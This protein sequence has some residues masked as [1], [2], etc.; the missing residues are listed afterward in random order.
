MSY[1]E[2]LDA[3]I[4][5][6]SQS[7]FEVSHSE[8]HP[9]LKSHQKDVVV[10]NLA[11][12][13]RANFLSFGLG[14]TLIQLETLRQIILHKGGR[15]LI[16]CPLG[17]KHEFVRDALKIGI[18][19]IKYIVN[20][21]QIEE[22]VD[23][24]I[25]NYER[26]RKGD[27]DPFEFIGVSFDE[28][29]ILRGL[30][31]QTTDMIMSMFKDI[32]F[33]FVCTATPSP[34]RYLELT[35]YAEYLGIMDRG[36]ILTRFFERNSTTAG[37]LKLYKRRQ[38]EFWYWMASWACFIT[39]PSDLGYDDTGY[40]LPPIN[41]H[42]HLVTF[43]RDLNVDTRSNQVSFLADSSKSLSEASKEKRESL[44]YRIDK[45]IEIVNQSPDDHFL[46]WHHLEAERIAIEK[47]VPDCKTVFGAQKTDL[48]ESILMDFSEGKIKY[49]GT[50]PEIAG[51]GCNFQ[52]HCH[53]AI[54]IGINYK[55]NDF[56]QAIHRIYR[57]MQSYP[58]DVHIILTDAEQEIFKELMRK[59]H[60]HI[61]IQT[62]M[63][64]IIKEFGLNSELYKEDLKREFFDPQK[65]QVFEGENF[66]A[67]NNDSVAECENFKDNSI[68]MIL[69]SIPF[70][71]H[72]EYSENINCFGHNETNE[73]F[74]EQMDHLT[75]NLF[76][77][78]QPGRIAFVH[79]K[80]RIRYSYMNGTGFTTIE[81]F[82]DH[83]NSHFLRHGFHLLAR[84]T[85]TTDVVAENAQTYRLGYTE[86]CKD[87][88][89]MGAGMPEY[90]LIFRKPPS[91]N[92]NAY[93]DVPVVHQKTEYERARW[94]LDAHDYWKS[95]GERLLDSNFLKQMDLSEVLKIWT[96]MEHHQ[97]YDYE[98]HVQLC[99]MLD[100]LG[101]LPT[102]Y[103]STPP[104]SN[105]PFVWSDIL[106]MNT[107]N[108]DQV[109]RNL[110]K[111]IC[112]LQLDIIKR[113]IELFSNKGDIIFDPFAGIFST[114][115]QAIKMERVG[116]GCELNS[117]YWKD[118]VKH[119]RTAELK[120]KSKTMTLF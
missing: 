88:T 62:E 106:R 29:S 65:R 70:G 51:S 96:E 103:M 13:R 84:I 100:D 24:Y 94:Q 48:K 95:N 64:N 87:G 57:F 36:Q 54:F 76:R 26:I 3:K 60:D 74:F 34:N 102:S 42:R 2:C 97:G 115:Y 85:V 53:K 14:K 46:L 56:I 75:P 4:K 111:H 104:I 30:D 61:N 38:K 5:L 9:I 12:G 117:F 78:L 15:V 114:P 33:R 37:D 79:V 1:N 108:A 93:A 10:W 23:F 22:D 63:T 83:T 110:D 55:F 90:I 107:L 41:I 58:C 109:K 66:K 20:T 7:G 6:A 47:A 82:S 98:K 31:T 19:N 11:G 71:N 92:A 112:P 45:M 73:K 89:K 77:I 81:P 99:K 28:A 67:I 72:Y 119:L 25:T 116:V 68:G 16:V 120:M 18:H 44:P 49:L 8:L 80:D 52:Y 27:I 69:T 50:K 113:G 91:S 35:G 118:G 17:V 86:K 101:K 105:S 43:E 21:S 40:S 39:K 59:W 32:P